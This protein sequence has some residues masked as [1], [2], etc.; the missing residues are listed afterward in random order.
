V[1]RVN[2]HPK[3]VK[4]QTGARAEYL[5]MDQVKGFQTNLAQH[6][7]EMEG[8]QQEAVPGRI[9]QA[10][11]AVLQNINGRVRGLDLAGLVPEREPKKDEPR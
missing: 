4:A 5:T 2:P 11:I 6:L 7:A 9:A 3:R 1:I 10:P 8:I